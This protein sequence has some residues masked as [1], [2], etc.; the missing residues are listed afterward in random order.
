[1]NGAFNV[2]AS[3]SSKR[4]RWAVNRKRQIA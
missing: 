1:L 4:R 2:H 3:Q